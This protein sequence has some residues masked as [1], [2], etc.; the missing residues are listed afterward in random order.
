MCGNR[1]GGR[2]AHLY[3]TESNVVD[4]VI[5]RDDS[6]VDSYSYLIQ[7]QGDILL[8]HCHY[9]HT[10]ISNRENSWKISQTQLP[11]HRSVTALSTFTVVGCPMPEPP[12]GATVE[13]TGDMAAIKCNNTQMTFHLV[14]S[15]TEWTGPWRN[16]T[17]GNFELNIDFFYGKLTERQHLFLLNEPRSFQL[18]RLSIKPM[19]TANLCTS[20]NKWEVFCF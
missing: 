16:C 8:C 6:D 14:C 4:I 2:E 3:K 9:S 7:Y 17:E 15:G 20:L 18:C 5:A 13:V 19:I 10:H 1:G 12:D 11:C